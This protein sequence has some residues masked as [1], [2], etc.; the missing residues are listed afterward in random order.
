MAA[1]T[2]WN[3]QGLSRPVM[4]LLYLLV[5]Q[6]CSQTVATQ[7]CSQTVVPKGV[8]AVYKRVKQK[9]KA[10]MEGGLIQ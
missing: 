2:S 8:S 7:Q 1:S 9:K 3:P 4:G 10:R 5:T 6:Q